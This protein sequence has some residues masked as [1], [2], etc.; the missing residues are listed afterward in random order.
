M[1][2]GNLDMPVMHPVKGVR[3]GITE[4]AIRYKNR[5]DLT[6]FEIAEGATVSAVFTQNSYCAAPVLLCREHLAKAAP[7]YLVI[8][9]GN[10]NAGTGTVGMDNA[11]ASCA[12]LS[13]L[14]G[15]AAERI[16][17]FSTGVI[18]EHLPRTGQDATLSLSLN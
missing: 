8:N 11:R 1:P 14:T 7:R 4:A 10:A 6:V 16:L 12:A 9:T 3:I 2:V 17:P 5:R 13:H 15:L 18:G